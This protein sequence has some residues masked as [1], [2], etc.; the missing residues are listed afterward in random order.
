M[1]NGTSYIIRDPSVTTITLTEELQFNTS[2]ITVTNATTN[3]TGTYECVAINV[4]DIDTQNATV[5]VQS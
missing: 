3:D 4:V 2:I 1:L 5:T